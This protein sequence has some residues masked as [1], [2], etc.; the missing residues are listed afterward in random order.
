[1]ESFAAER[2]QPVGQDFSLRISQRPHRVDVG[3]HL[4]K[5]IGKFRGITLRPWKSRCH[6]PGKSFHIDA[7]IGELFAEVRA[8]IEQ[9]IDVPMDFPAGLVCFQSSGS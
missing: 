1:M 4:E 6:P 8:L 5:D 7:A 3:A 9:V 2:L